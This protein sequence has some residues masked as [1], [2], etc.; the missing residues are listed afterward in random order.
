MLRQVVKRTMAQVHVCQSSSCRRQGSEAVLLEIEELASAVDKTCQVKASGCL[1]LCNQAPAAMVVQKK[2]PWPQSR[3]K[4]TYFVRLVST[5]KN[6]DVVIEATGKKPPTGSRELQKRLSDARCVRARDSCIAVLRWNG[7][8]QAA[9]QLGDLKARQELLM[10]A[11]YPKGEIPKSTE[12]KMPSEIEKYSL[13]LLEK[14][15][16]V[17][18][19]SAIFHFISKD[20]KR[21]TPNPR[22]GGRRVP[23]PK[24]W[25]TTLL[26]EVGPNSDGPLP[27][28]ERD[29]T[30]ISGAKDWEQGRCDILIKIY[31]GGA[32]TSWLRNKM[33]QPSEPSTPRVWLSQ[34]LQTS[35]IP[36][37]TNEPSFTPAS[38]SLLLGGTGVVALPQIVNHRDPYGKIGIAMKRSQQLHVPIDLILSCRADDV[39]LLPDIVHLCR[40]G[41]HASGTKGLRRCTL[42]LTSTE[43]CKEQCPFPNVSTDSIEGEVEELR[44]LP[45]G[46]V[47]N[48]RMSSELVLEAVSQMPKPCRVV[49]S[50]PSGFNSAARKMLL[51]ANEDETTITILET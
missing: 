15:T 10:M 27:W 6:E 34:P 11:G 5:E 13:W 26:A 7:A 2:Q 4:E 36:S 38:V 3:P 23:T 14:V 31:C 24:T 22:G 12:L 1:G 50:G 47:L 37:L 40:E 39:L 21:G 30:P 8:I 33:N 28:I 25:H 9:T 32:A 51:E 19:H 42:L 17:T 29:Y 46:S 41:N 45:N 20:R 49:V 18:R 35:T 44:N 43:S 48:K 16:Y